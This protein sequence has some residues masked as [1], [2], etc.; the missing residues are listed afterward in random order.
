MRFHGILDDDM[1]VYSLGDNGE[2]VYS[3]FNIDQHYDYLLSIGVE[4]LIELSFMPEALASHSNETVFHYKGGISPPKDWNKW[5]QL[6]TAFVKH[7]VDRYGLDLMSRIQLEVWN[8]PNCGFWTGSQAEYFK[9]LQ[10]TYWA[11]KSVSPKLRVGGPATCHLAWIPETL[12]FAKANGMELDFIS[13]HIYPTDWG[14]NASRT[15]MTEKLSLAR[16]QAG[17]TPLYITEYNSGLWC[18]NHDTNYASA[19]LISQIP[20]LRPYVDIFSYWTFSDIFEEWPFKSAPFQQ[21]F[22]LQTIYGVPKPAFRA[23]ELL[24]RAGEYQVATTTS[25]SAKTVDIWTAR[26][27][28]HLMTFISNWDTYGNLPPAETV[29]V[30]VLGNTAST[31]KLERIDSHHANPR[32]AWEKMGSPTYPTKAQIAAMMAASEVIPTQIHAVAAGTWTL[33]VPPLGVAVLTIQ[34]H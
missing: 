21:G 34:L 27:N 12:A 15:V 29:T 7:L 5:S 13:S 33:S 25:G 23:F 32:G 14:L 20:K 19:F 6:I 10:V 28:T 4:P 8:E 9:L 22:G 2:P 11:I 16:Q 26:N 18:C 17:N 31:A 30:T 24:H 3:F 1:S